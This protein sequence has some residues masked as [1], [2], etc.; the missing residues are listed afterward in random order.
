M[1]GPGM[2]MPQEVSSQLLAKVNATK[3]L[4]IV[5]Q[6]CDHETRNTL[7]ASHFLLN[8]PLIKRFFGMICCSGANERKVNTKNPKI[9]VDEGF[10]NLAKECDPEAI[11]TPNVI[12]DNK[13]EENKFEADNSK[14][15]LF[16]P[17]QGENK[18]KKL[19]TKKSNL[20]LP[21]IDSK[22]KAK[23]ILG[24]ASGDTLSIAPP[25]SKEAKS[26]PKEAS[27]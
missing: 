6:S 1:K 24:V 13:N 27:N 8:K 21:E 20:K 23:E 9:E 4:E 26:L 2:L 12:N 18:N 15:S 22:A 17:N 10:E 11:S 16:Y 3:N 14:M 7:L 19:K 25:P 5:L